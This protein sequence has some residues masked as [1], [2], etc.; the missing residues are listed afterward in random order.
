MALTPPTTQEISDNLVAQ[1]Q[2]SLNQT[3]PLLPRSFIRV[4]SKALAAVFIIVYKYAGFIALQQ[5]VK[6]ASFEET[7]IN[8][9]KFSPLI[10][11]GERIGVGRPT[12]ATRAEVSVT[13]TVQQQGG[14]IP[15]GVLLF[16]AVNGYTYRLLSSVLLNSASVTGTIRAVADQTDTGGRGASGNLDPNDI[17]SFTTPQAGVETDTVVL[18]QISTAADGEDVEVY[19]RRIITRFSA[20]PQGGAYSDYRIWGEE[21][22]GII[23]VYPYTGAPGQVDVYSEA[24]VASSGDPDGIPTAAQLLA[25]LDNINL[26]QDGLA[27]RRNANAFVNSLPITRVT[28]DVQVLGISGVSDLGKVQ[29]DIVTALAQYFAAAEPFIAGLSIPPRVD[30]ITRVTASAI[31][32]D[33]VTAFNGTFTSVNL[34]IPLVGAVGIYILGEGEKSKIGTVTYL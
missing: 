18:A 7:T 28:F 9:V 33:I 22:E 27:S 16:S 3:I 31:V 24:T 25:V 14:T 19:R 34:N 4:L 30:Q 29:A 2:A 8:G 12:V 11:W 21:V 26:D 10:E 32:E 1:I 13:I 5:F 23:N 15:A 17:V 6:F 20:R